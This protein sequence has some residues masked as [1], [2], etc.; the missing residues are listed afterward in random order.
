MTDI[1][2]SDR[3]AA[4]EV[5]R[6]LARPDAE[7]EMQSVDDFDPWDIFPAVYGSYS[8][9]FDDCALQVLRELR[10]DI[11]PRRDDLGAQMLREMLCVAGLCDY[12]T[13]PRGCFPTTD[14]K[15]LLP[16]LIERWEG[17]AKRHWED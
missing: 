6:I 14:F 10:D 17:Y 7:R 8:S 15:P 1:Y 16:E 5:R 11:W 2:A 12:G 13:S 3:K 9:D 4:E